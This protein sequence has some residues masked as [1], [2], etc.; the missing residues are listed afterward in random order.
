[1]SEPTPQSQPV[2]EPKPKSQPI[3]RDFLFGA[4]AGGTAIGAGWLATKNADRASH[5]RATPCY[6]QCGEDLIASMLFK[7][8]KIDKPTYID[9]GAYRP[10]QSNNTYLFYLAG[11]HGVLVEPNV[12]LTAELKRERPR[13]VTLPVGIGF[14]DKEEL[15]DYYRMEIAE[16]NTFD[17]EEAKRRVERTG[18]GVK[19]LETVKVPLL[20]LN[21]VIAEHF[22]GKAPDFL[23][24]DVE[25]LDLA[26]LKSL[27]FEK[28]R[29]KIICAEALVVL[30]S[31]MEPDVGEFLKTK[32][33]AMRGM[34]FPN[35]IFVDE[36]VLN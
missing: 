12:D 33:Y 2:T 34:T 10:V 16:W 29:P 21:K 8:M 20:P 23:S 27:D 17:A 18:G 30:T 15:M 5:E 7:H 4:L 1:M 26:I 19:I 14:S 35:Q 25:G 36:K 31:K 9:I 6:S 28:Y 11:G 32:G 24:V 22:G 13:D 3:R